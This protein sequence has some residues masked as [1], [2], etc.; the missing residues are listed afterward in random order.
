MLDHYATSLRDQLE[1]HDNAN[2]AVSG[3]AQASGSGIA[4]GLGR[5]GLLKKKPLA[6]LSHTSQAAKQ[7]VGSGLTSATRTEIQAVPRPS[8]N[9]AQ[10]QD[11]DV[12]ATPS[13]VKARGSGFKGPKG[14][15]GKQSAAVNR[16]KT[17]DDILTF[18]GITVT[19]GET[20][21][22]SALMGH[23]ASPANF[24][25]AGAEDM[26]LSV[27]GV[28]AG[29]DLFARATAEMVAK[30]A[31]EDEDAEYEDG[32]EDTIDPAISGL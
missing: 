16:A 23:F 21:A 15:K 4:R 13:V 5:P 6:S 8:G 2:S 1:Q 17:Q 10:G 3:N 30:G 19:E 12:R 9:I 27:A 14:R 25:M 11:I 20:D 22:I 24:G 28:H 29:L 31:Q 32:E 18:G 26:D 7:E